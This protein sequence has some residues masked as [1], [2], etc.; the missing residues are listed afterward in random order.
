MNIIKIKEDT[1][2]KDYAVCFKKKVIF[3]KANSKLEATEK[4]FK[5][6]SRY[7]K[8]YFYKN[9]VVELIPD[10]VIKAKKLRKVQAG[11]ASSIL[12][13]ALT[14]V[15]VIANVKTNKTEY[16]VSGCN[17]VSNTLVTTVDII[18]QQ[19]Q[20]EYEKT[21]NKLQLFVTN[22]LDS[23]KFKKCE[24]SEETNTEESA[25][26]EV[27]FASN[28]M[29]VNDQYTL[30]LMSL[31][32]A[33]TEEIVTIDP[34]AEEVNEVEKT[35]ETQKEETKE[36]EEKKETTGKRI[37]VDKRS[38]DILYRIVE[39]EAGDGDFESKQHV[40]NVIINRVLSKYFPNSIEDVVFQ[41]KQFSPISDGRYYKVT[42][43]QSTIDAVDYALAHGDNTYG[44]TYFANLS[45]VKNK[46]TVAWFNSLEFIFKDTE[47]H[48]FFRDPAQEE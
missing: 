21:S 48:S 47:G 16:T 37:T 9:V 6:F 40:A 10:E 35:Q 42:I 23:L 41:P 8:S 1:I 5:R 38:K 24:S 3:V 12:V 44:A 26:P 31:D 45:L 14:V 29:S 28:E 39:A 7:Q 15:S 27:V 17:K 33:M 32:V 2:I 11:L 18:E 36:T 19:A 13:T 46:K 43:A 20:E 34:P 30:A 4:A 25:A 22:Q